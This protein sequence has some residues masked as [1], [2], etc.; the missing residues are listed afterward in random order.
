MQEQRLTHVPE[1]KPANE[2]VILY[3]NAKQIES[4]AIAYLNLT[5]TDEKEKKREDIIGLSEY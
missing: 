2:T 3:K 4:A 1:Q 5:L